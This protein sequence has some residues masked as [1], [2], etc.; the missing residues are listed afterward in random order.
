MRAAFSYREDAAVPDFADDRPV[1]IF[2]GHCALCSGVVQFILRHDR[3]AAFRLL[4]AQ[5][6][7]GR[8]LYLHY[9]LDPEE[10]ETYILLQN[11]VAYF[12]SDATIRLAEGLGR[13]WSGA[14]VLQVVPVSWRD[15]LYRL[16]A[17]N[18]FRLFARR[19]TCY[20]PD[21]AYQDRFL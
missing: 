7:L 10:L 18:R 9:G 15:A 17:R 5:S 4:P 6:P 12:R 16:I 11:G 1:V 21:P 2:D 8:A 20:L 3:S 19:A 14:A 13:P